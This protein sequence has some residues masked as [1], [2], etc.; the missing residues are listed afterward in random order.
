MEGVR[1]IYYFRVLKDMCKHEMRPHVR[2]PPR[3]EGIFSII[4]NSFKPISAL[5][6]LLYEFFHL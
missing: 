1:F 3:Y 2:I 5:N 6:G 4:Q